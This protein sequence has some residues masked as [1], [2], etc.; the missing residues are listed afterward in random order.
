MCDTLQW[1]VKVACKT[2][3]RDDV[4]GENFRK[5]LKRGEKYIFDNELLVV[6]KKRIG[7]AIQKYSQNSDGEN[8]I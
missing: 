5:I 8:G 2:C 4:F 6:P 1:P 3:S 7:S